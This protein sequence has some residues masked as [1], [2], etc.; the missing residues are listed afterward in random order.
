[1]LQQSRSAPEGAYRNVGLEGQFFYS[2]H[3]RSTISGWTLAT[4]VPVAG[5]EAKLRKS[6]ITLAAAAGV[7][8]LVAVGLA[9][10]FG[11]RIAGPVSALARSAGALSNAEPVIVEQH[12][13]VAE[14]EEVSRAFHE[15]A[16]QLRIHEEELNYQRQ[17]LETITDHAPSML[18][19][20]DTQGRATFVNPAT[21]RMTGYTAEELLGQ[22][23]HEKIHHSHPDGAPYPIEDC[24]LNQAVTTGQSVH[25][26]EDAFV[27]QDGSFFAALCSASPILRNDV[28]V[29]TVIEVQDITQRKRAEEERR[30]MNQELERRVEER[31]TELVRSVV[32]REKL[33]E[34]LL[35]AQ[36]MESL[37]TLAGGI[38]HDFNNILNII[39]GYVATLRDNGDPA[40]AESLGVIRQTVERGASVVQQLLTVARKSELKFEPVDVNG[41][42][43]QLAKLLGETFSKTINI[44]M[45]LNPRIPLIIAD[46]NRLSQ[47][48]LNLCVNARDAMG[49]GGTLVLRTETA[50]GKDLRARFHAAEDREYVCIAVADTGAGM[51]A[52]TR[53]RVFDPFFTTKGQGEGTGLGLTVVYGIAQS[54]RGFIDIESEPG[55]GSTFRVYLPVQPADDTRGAAPP[56]AAGHAR[57]SAYGHGTL[58]FVEDEEPQ[59]D[60]I[61]GF[62]QRKGYK[63]LVARDGVEAV[64]LHKQHKAEIAAVILDLGLPR[65]SGW[66][67]FLSMKQEQPTVKAIFASGYIK[68]DVRSEMLRQGVIEILYKPYEPADLAA[69]IGAVINEPTATSAG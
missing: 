8:A 68:A 50:A 45:E 47:A 32:Q 12:T 57:T 56:A 64:E 36:K 23:V 14:V 30:R 43:R 61:Q 51:D 11:R 40:T 10:V 44:A 22:V 19:M 18:V 4:G 62:L 38:A 39:L 2:A 49:S 21:E 16:E 20:I 35:Q 7:M 31:T 3:S 46:P 58:L 5:V 15:A 41:F 54:H 27:R 66:E 9:L 24:S 1:L 25:D 67:A 29:G 63:V 26:H 17:L 59:L 6:T 33:Q 34:Q 42:L 13:G 69:K 60:L 52:T 53:E 65:L 48:L 37:G 55:R 28:P